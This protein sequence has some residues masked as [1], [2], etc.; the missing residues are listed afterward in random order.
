MSNDIKRFAKKLCDE[1]HYFS[2][3]DDDT[4]KKIM[5]LLHGYGSNGADLISIAPLIAPRLKEYLFISPNAVASAPLFSMQ[6]F[7]WFSLD[8][9]LQY[10]I[11][12]VQYAFDVIEVM[13]AHLAQEYNLSCNNITLAGFSQGG[14]MSLMTSLYR[15]RG[16]EQVICFSGWC[17][18]NMV[19]EQD[20]FEQTCPIAMIHG[21][22]DSV[23]LLDWAQKSYDFAVSKG[24]EINFTI[25]PNLEH[26]I[27]QR[28]ID[29]LIKFVESH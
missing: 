26:S 1:A 19:H 14:F 5:L 28:A 22:M 27:D 6:S 7:Q 20:I 11:D 18:P 8:D 24:A 13:V 12:E 23:V 17:D 4:P 15:V 29:M 3:S 2:L 21:D 25:L 9:K 10:K 16:L